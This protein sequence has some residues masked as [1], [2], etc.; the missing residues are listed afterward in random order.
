[1]GHWQ[2]RETGHRYS[3]TEKELALEKRVRGWLLKVPHQITI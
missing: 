3:E 1:M 2:G